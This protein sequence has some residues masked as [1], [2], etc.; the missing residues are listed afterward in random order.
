[1]AGENGGNCGV[2]ALTALL[3]AAHRGTTEQ[4]EIH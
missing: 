1:M 4:A 3:Q 2:L